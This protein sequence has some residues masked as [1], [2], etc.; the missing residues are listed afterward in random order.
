MRSYVFYPALLT[1]FLVFACDS[2]LE[3]A[4]SPDTLEKS[5]YS[6]TT[7]NSVIP[8]IDELRSVK[9]PEIPNADATESIEVDENQKAQSQANNSTD[10]SEIIA[11]GS[12]T[13]GQIS[14]EIISGVGS[15]QSIK[16]EQPLEEESQDEKS[17]QRY[18]GSTTEYTYEEDVKPLLDRFCVPCHGTAPNKK[19]A[20]NFVLDRYEAQGAE[21]GIEKMVERI[22]I[23]TGNGTMPPASF[24]DKPTDQ[25]KEIIVDWANA[26]GPLQEDESSDE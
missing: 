14:S 8:T 17:N 13:E 5:R 12:S 7:G 10:D 15:N 4:E 1:F 21:L 20:G 6:N 26:G 24:A 25:E 11:I 22:A 19:V 18:Q 23:R 9:A 2:N 3:N 16:L